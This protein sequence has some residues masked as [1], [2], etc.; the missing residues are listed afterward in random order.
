MPLI[1]R[2][3]DDLS[4]K[5]QPVHQAYLALWCHVFDEA[6]VEIRSP[7]D[8]AFEAGFSGARGEATWRTR[9][10]RLEE[11]GVIATK[12]GLAGQFQY[13]LLLNPIKVIA[14]HYADRPHDVAYT[15]LLSRLSQVGADDLDY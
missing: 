9:M 11:L 4:G 1:G 6:F 8:L 13:V 2:I 14:S 10:K 7:R 3:L 5:G 15:A 12:S